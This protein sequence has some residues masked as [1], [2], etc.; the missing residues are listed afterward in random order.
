MGSRSTGTGHRII[1]IIN[2]AA[3]PVP[4]LAFSYTGGLLSSITD[5]NQ[6]QVA[7]GFT[8]GNLSSVSVIDGQD[9]QWQYG[10]TTI[11][12]E[13]YLST[14]STI[15][16]AGGGNSTASVNYDNY[17]R[18]GSHT[19]ANGAQRRCGYSGSSDT[20]QVILSTAT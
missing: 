6:R 11:G 2:D 14:V 8:D 18:V 15:N 13:P 12:G 4:L 10:Y 3:P 19:D 7:Y 16:P 20:V 5:W 1:S 17:G 9:M